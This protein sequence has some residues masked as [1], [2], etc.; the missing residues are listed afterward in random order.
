MRSHSHCNCALSSC[1]GHDRASTENLESLPCQKPASFKKSE[2]P[3]P[4]PLPP[5][6]AP[7][8]PPKT[9]PQPPP[10]PP[11]NRPPPAPPTIGKGLHRRSASAGEGSS[12][13]GDREAPRAKLKPFFWDKVVGSADHSMVWD[14]I[15]QGS[16][17]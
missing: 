12:R 9:K 11:N 7:P 4:P 16:F 1:Q 14:E 8:L 2:P 17:Q 5:P 15:R 13:N 3:P 10:P 6:E